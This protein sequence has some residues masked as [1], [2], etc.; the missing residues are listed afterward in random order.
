MCPPIATNS[1]QALK[2]QLWFIQG[3]YQ[4][5]LDAYNQLVKDFGKVNRK[6]WVE[7]Q[8]K[9]QLYSALQESIKELIALKAVRLWS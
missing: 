9:I 2:E 1:K 3:E 8:E 6:E 7:L 4:Q 5:H